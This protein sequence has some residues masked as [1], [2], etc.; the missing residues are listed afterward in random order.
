MRQLILCAALIPVLAHAPQ[1]SACLLPP[2]PVIAEIDP[3]EKKCLA[4]MIYGEARGEP[5]QGQIAVAYTAMNRAHSKTVCDVVLA[6]YQYSVFNGNS[7]LKQV[8]ISLDLEPNFRNDQDQHSWKLA[9][10]I[11]KKVLNRGVP[12]PTQGAT[13]YLAPRLM[14]SS[15]YRY[16]RWSRQYTLVVVIDNHRFYRAWYPRN[17][18]S[19]S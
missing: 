1:E 17:K 9:L 18:K 5:T 15:G 11:A 4:T 13:H 7:K 6:P 14:A 12:D 8:A 10:E 19:E 2:W 16:P 3:V